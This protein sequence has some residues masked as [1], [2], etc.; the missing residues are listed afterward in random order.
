MKSIKVKELMVPLADY[1]TVS[2]DATLYQAVVALEEAQ[3]GVGAER[4][5]HRAVLV[6][7]KSNRVVG[8]LSRW[9]V[10]EGLEPKYDT[11]K[12]LKET[13]RYGF[14]PEYIKSMIEEYG[15]WRKP[16]EDLC[17]R[18]AEQKVKDIMYAPDERELV[19]EEASLGEAIHQMVVCHHQSLLVKRGDVIVGILRLSDVFKEVCDGIKACKI[20]E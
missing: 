13:S 10:I 9:D 2:E 14:S 20:G 18:A 12:G 11:I 3:K 15:L 16:L 8:K 19:D 5:K 17:R 6:L 1:A 4:D 7:D